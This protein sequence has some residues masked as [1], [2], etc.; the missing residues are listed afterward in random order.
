MQF[1]RFTFLTV[2]RNSLT[3]DD[4][5]LLTYDFIFAKN[6]VKRTGKIISLVLRIPSI[7]HLRRRFS[8]FAS[9]QLA[10]KFEIS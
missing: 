7:F 3:G 5:Y 1:Q 6:S 9:D 4:F 8:F 10:V 2:Q